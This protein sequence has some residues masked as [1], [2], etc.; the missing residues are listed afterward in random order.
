MNLAAFLTAVAA[1]GVDVV[2]PRLTPTSNNVTSTTFAVFTSEPPSFPD[3]KPSPEFFLLHNRCGRDRH[4][5]QSAC[6]RALQ[7]CS[8]LRG[9]VLVYVLALILLGRQDKFTREATQTG[10]EGLIISSSIVTRARYFWIRLVTRRWT[11][12]D[13]HFPGERKDIPQAWL[14]AE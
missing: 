6:P 14:R 3:Q 10:A 2:W 1:S 5:M 12:E 4:E 9:R 11:I 8:L 7:P 13:K